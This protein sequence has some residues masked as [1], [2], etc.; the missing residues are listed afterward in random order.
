MFEEDWQLLGL[1]PTRDLLAIKRAYAQRLRVTRPD[2]DAQAYQALREAYERAQQWAR[3]RAEAGADADAPAAG[4]APVDA[5]DAV[6]PDSVAPGA[7]AP[8]AAAQALAD[9]VPTQAHMDASDA[10]GA[11]DLSPQAPKAPAAD[12]ADAASAASLQ[13]A[14][15]A[16]AGTVAAPVLDVPD[17]EMVAG[18]VKY[19][20]R[21][22]QHQGETALMAYWPQLKQAL[23]E[24]PLSLHGKASTGFADLVIRRPLMPSAFIAL[25]QD[26]FTWLDDFRSERLIG[27]ERMQ[28]LQAVLADRLMRLTTNPEVLQHHAPVLHLFGLHERKKRLAAYAFATLMGAPLVAQFEEAGERVLTTLGIAPYVQRHLRDYFAFAQIARVAAL[29]LLWGLGVL[30]LQ[31][32]L[33]TSAM[34]MGLGLVLGFLGWVTAVW[35]GIGFW[36]WFGLRKQPGTMRDKLMVWHRHR[37]RPWLGLALLVAACGFALWAHGSSWP[38][39]PW[40]PWLTL[41]LL[42]SLL[43]WP[44]DPARGFAAMGAVAVACAIFYR[45]LGGTSQLQL[46]LSLAC[47]WTLCGCWVY[48]GRHWG[49]AQSSGNFLPLGPLWL[50][51]PVINTLFLCDRWGYKYALAPAALAL[52]MSQTLWLGTKG[53]HPLAAWVICVLAWGWLQPLLTRWSMRGVVKHETSR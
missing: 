10:E 40:L 28:A 23:A 41:T 25:L 19:T 52:A 30:A 14:L 24:L 15:D 43:L 39:L 16:A 38:L 5:P 9:P 53:F 47:A 26:H 36:G 20:E 29:L 4:T 2:D 18:L 8:Q 7:P 13:A 22:F 32:D 31:Q 42:G 6:A 44:Q 48:E 3:W 1:Q 50:V 17:A 11:L 51:A 37:S 35:L 46:S 21:V 27:F 33:V 12:G 34:G 49:L 45:W